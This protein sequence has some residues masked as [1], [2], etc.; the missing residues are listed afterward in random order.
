[1][2]WHTPARRFDGSRKEL[3]DLPDADP[4]LLEDDLSNLR[5]I[6]RCFG[7]IRAVRKHIRP[8]LGRVNARTAAS[9]LDLA[10]GSADHPL[11]LVEMGRRLGRE[12]SVTAMD[13]H[14]RMVELS[15]RRT[16]HE[17]GIAILEGDIRTPG[18]EDRS[19]DIVLCSLAL[20]HFSDEEA[21]E[22]VRTMARLSRVGFLVNDLRRSRMAA[23][24]AWL[25]TRVSTGNPMTRN[26]AVVSV[27]RGFTEAELTAMGIASGI[28]RVSVHREPL[29]RLVLVGEH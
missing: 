17:P 6:N 24:A 7:G 19:F 16:A 8:L 29:Y 28:G 12:I 18:L 27:W 20:H 26:D 3:M 23:S 1:M 13:R 22:I 5:T 14:P 11:A 15:R 9:V 10:T 2:V 25:W 21:G 4:A